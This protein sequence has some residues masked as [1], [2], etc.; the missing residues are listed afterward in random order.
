MDDR[1]GMIAWVER[2]MARMRAQSRVTIDVAGARPLSGALVIYVIDVD[3]RRTVLAAAP[4]ALC[5][6]SSYPTPPCVVPE[7]ARTAS[8]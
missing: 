5:V 4:H 3:G 1:T 2:W 7:G 8:V 6:L